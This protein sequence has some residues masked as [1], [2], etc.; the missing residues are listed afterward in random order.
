M[1]DSEHTSLQGRLLV[2]APSLVDPNFWRSV[3]LIAE[4]NS[5]GAMGLVLNR[6]L[7]VSVD[8]AVEPLS[9]LVDSTAC[10]YRGGPVSPEAVVALAEFN[11][12]DVSA[13]LTF[14]QIGFLGADPDVEQLQAATSRARI[15]AGYAGWSGGQLE[16]ELGEE[17]WIVA[18]PVADDVFTHDADGLWATV[19][20]RLGGVPAFISL[21]PPDPSMN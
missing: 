18:D 11:E 15:F 9:S 5:E 13:E 4:H 2:A 10:V 19:L 20:T 16:A 3:V 21:M 6:P 8:E 12:P 14:G 7:D 1:K 17:A